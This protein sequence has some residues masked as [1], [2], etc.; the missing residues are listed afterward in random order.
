MVDVLHVL[1]IAMKEGAEMKNRGDGVKI[2]QPVITILRDIWATAW[3]SL[4]V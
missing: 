4:L 1:K 2:F 3:A